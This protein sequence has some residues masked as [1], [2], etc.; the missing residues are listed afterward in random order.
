LNEAHGATLILVT[1]DTDLARRC[2]HTVTIEA[3]R[4]AQRASLDGHG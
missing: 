1:H 3:G 2:A 4:V